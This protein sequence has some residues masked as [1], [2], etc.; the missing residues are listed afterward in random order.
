MPNSAS[1]AKRRKLRKERYLVRAQMLVRKKLVKIVKYKQFSIT[2]VV[3]MIE[4]PGAQW[5]RKS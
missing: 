4:W 5:S 1:V 2:E 3:S